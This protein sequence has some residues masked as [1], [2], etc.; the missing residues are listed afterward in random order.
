ML[1][2]KIK[3]NLSKYSTHFLT[4]KYHSIIF[5][6]HT[7]R[8]IYVYRLCS[9]SLFFF[10]LVPKPNDDLMW[11]YRVSSSICYGFVSASFVWI[12]LLSIFQP[13]GDWMRT[14]KSIQNGLVAQSTVIILNFYR[15]SSDTKVFWVAKIVRRLL[16]KPFIFGFSLE[17]TIL[18]ENNRR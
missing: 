15:H 2:R 5:L 10:I 3:T 7:F 18:C 17:C 8:S 16:M 1:F 13:F 4:H 6:L 12:E 11:F 9:W 14:S